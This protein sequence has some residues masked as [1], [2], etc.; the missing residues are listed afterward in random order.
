MSKVFVEIDAAT[1]LVLA[2]SDAKVKDSP[3]RYVVKTNDFAVAVG[4]HCDNSTTPA[5]FTPRSAPVQGDM[6]T[7]L[8]KLN[9]AATLQAEAFAML[10]SLGGAS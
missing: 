9:N 7:V 3:G 8:A 2:I 5:T 10:Q 4:W 1:N 6:A